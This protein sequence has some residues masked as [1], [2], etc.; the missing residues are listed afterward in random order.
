MTF[1]KPFNFLEQAQEAY[2]LRWLFVEIAYLVKHILTVLP[3]VWNVF[4]PRF[5]H[6]IYI[7][8]QIHLPP[9][10]MDPVN[11]AIENQVENKMFITTY[12][13]INLK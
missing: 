7:V 4:F 9:F 13:L 2:L 1:F 3:L 5:V 6:L 11:S 12:I 10:K 8:G